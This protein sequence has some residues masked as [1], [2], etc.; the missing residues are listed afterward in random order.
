MSG[1]AHPSFCSVLVQVPFLKGGVWE[2]EQPRQGVGRGCA[3]GGTL[4]S[5]AAR[6]LWHGHPLQTWRRAS[7]LSLSFERG[8]FCPA[9][10]TRLALSAS[11][12]WGIPRLSLS[13]QW[14]E[15]APHLLERLVATTRIK[16]VSIPFL[17]SHLSPPDKFK[18]CPCY[19]RKWDLQGWAWICHEQ[20]SVPADQCC[21]LPA[22][23]RAG[24]AGTPPLCCE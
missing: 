2:P 8:H 18:L 16:A 1:G 10:W 12:S 21:S 24:V 22:A 13:L 6:Q 15:K 9:L 7:A 4:P 14:Q 20:E 5:K 19:R 23:F 3:V 17:F 11:L